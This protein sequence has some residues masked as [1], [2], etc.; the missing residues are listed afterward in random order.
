MDEPTRGID[1]NAKAEIYK[2]MKRLVEDGTCIIFF[3]S[4]VPEIV[5]IA[6]RILIMKKGVIAAEFTSGVNK[7]EIMQTIL[8]GSD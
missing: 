1:I 2:I 5:E 6:D 7:N 8:K 4:E 3:S